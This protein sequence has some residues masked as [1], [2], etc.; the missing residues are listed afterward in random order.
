MRIRRGL[1]VF[2]V[3]VA[4]CGSSSAAPQSPASAQGSGAARARCGPAE[5]RTLAASGLARVYSLRGAVYGCSVKG[6]KSYRLG[7]A[8]RSIREGRV[9]S[10]AVAGQDAAYG[11]TQY[12]VDTVSASVI[13]RRLSDGTRLRDLAATSR[14]LGPE[15]FESV[16][17]IV[18]K[19]T[20]AVAWIA[21]G[22]SVISGHASDVEVDRADERGHSLLDSGAGI[23]G[24][25]LRLR[26]S[27][28]SWRH[29]AATRTATLR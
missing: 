6:R 28:I 4:A 3:S 18:V 2:V 17:S 19:R 7:N 23:D 12:G 20:G 22:G 1:W 25:S 5:A 10:V 16:D 8:S 29:A 11:L 15:S 14:P 27:T 9:G 26:D 24:R 21:E 13:V